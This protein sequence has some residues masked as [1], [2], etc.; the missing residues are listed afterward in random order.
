MQLHDHTENCFQMICH[1][2]DTSSCEMAIKIDVF[3]NSFE[4]V[5]LVLKLT[6]SL[7]FL[8]TFMA[9]FS[10][11]NKLG[12]YLVSFHARKFSDKTGNFHPYVEKVSNLVIFLVLSIYV[13]LI[14][15]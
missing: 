5:L 2:M 1:L 4:I 12:E 8:I 13:P 6:P 10:F 15:S 3:Q 9:N 11:Y 14:N 7:T